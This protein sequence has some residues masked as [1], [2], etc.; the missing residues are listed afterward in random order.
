MTLRAETAESSSDPPVRVHDSAKLSG[1]VDF[2]ANWELDLSSVQSLI[3]DVAS[4]PP[5][6]PG[7]VDELVNGARIASLDERAAQ[8][9]GAPV[10]REEMIGRSV[11]SFA[12]PFSW[13]ALAE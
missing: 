11:A 1:E 8:V 12:P 13:Q 5:L 3:E 6:P 2:I 10:P 7:W 9:V 4:G